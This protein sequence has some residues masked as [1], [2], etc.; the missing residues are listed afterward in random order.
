MKVIKEFLE[1]NVQLSKMSKV[2]DVGFGRGEFTAML[3]DSCG[4]DKEYI[5]IELID[6]A[7][8]AA[9]E[10]FK[11]EPVKVLKMDASDMSFED[12]SFD[13]VCLSNTLHHL[14]NR[15]DVI[16]EMK[17][18]VKPDGY[19]LIQ[20]MICD[21]QTEKQMTHVTLHHFSA[22]IDRFFGRHHEETFTRTQLDN[23]YEELELLPFAKTEY[24]MHE[25]YPIED[26]ESVVKNIVSSMRKG[27]DRVE[28][29]EFHQTLLEEFEGFADDLIKTGFESATETLYL[30]RGSSLWQPIS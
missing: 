8:D 16:S 20:E 7:V 23:L 26:E 6:A 4:R 30:L 10:N 5:G 27:I 24:L 22:K 1:S 12:N 29:L 15:E 3:L 13:L 2:L 21:N 14:S 19:I 25:I 18:V 28:D 17:R 11:D 9:N